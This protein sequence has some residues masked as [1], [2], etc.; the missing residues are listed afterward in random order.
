ME[1][2]KNLATLAEDSL[3]RL[4]E[5]RT[6]WFEGEWITNALTQDRA[7]R[8]HRAF[9]GLGMGP[10]RIG[11]LYM[12]NHPLIYPVFQG[13]FRTGGAAVPVMFQL[14]AEELRFV[15]EDTQAHLLVTDQ[16]NL[17]KARQAVR[18]LD[19]VQAIVGRDIAHSTRSGTFVG[20]GSCRKWRPL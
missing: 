12:T 16:A 4:G 15:L 17:E 5:R 19:S 1:L 6:L 13:L 9:A 18:G 20:P 14:Q 3:Q 10:G 2:S 11:A 8:L 7:R